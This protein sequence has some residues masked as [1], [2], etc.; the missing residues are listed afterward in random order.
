MRSNKTE[1]PKK[2]KKLKSKAPLEEPDEIDQF[3]MKI[4]KSQLDLKEQ[5]ENKKDITIE[6]QDENNEI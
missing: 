1:I 3:F 5:Q 6:N 2:Q 4:K